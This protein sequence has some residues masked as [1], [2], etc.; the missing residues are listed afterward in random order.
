M[1]HDSRC[2]LICSEGFLQQ[3]GSSGGAKVFDFEW[4]TYPLEIESRPIIVHQFRFDLIGFFHIQLLRILVKFVKLFKPI[5]AP[6]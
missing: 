5:E 4:D 3:Q 1:N 6:L 2:Q